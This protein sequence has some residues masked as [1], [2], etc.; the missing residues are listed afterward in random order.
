MISVIMPTHKQPPLLHY[1]LLSVMS[2]WIDDFELI[3]VD[4][5]EDHYFKK[6][7]EDLFKTAKPLN[8]YA[9]RMNKIKIIYPD[10]YKTNPGAMK[11]LGFKYCK[12][13]DDFVVFLDHDDFLGSNIL[14]HMRQACEEFPNTEMFSTKYT[15]LSYKNNQLYTN[16]VTFFGGQKCEDTKT[17]KIGPITYTFAKNQD[18]Y[19]SFHPFKATMHPKIISKKLIRD[20]RFTFITDTMTGDDQMWPVVSHSFVETYIPAIGYIYVAYLTDY[21]TNS[22]DK[23]RSPSETSRRYAK[24]CE[25]YE[26]MLNEIGY[27]KEK[28]VYNIK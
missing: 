12:Q 17:V 1:T 11:M 5:S 14:T 21:L 10:G 23:K 6:A 2:Q 27:K 4:A 7:A 9:Q 15:S 25:E 26:K 18:V 28:N 16:I 19:K 20:N 3:V 24:C 8:F 22:C 13:D